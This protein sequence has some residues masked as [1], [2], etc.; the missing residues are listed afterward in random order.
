MQTAI[1]QLHDFLIESAARLP[2]K[3]ALVCEGQR[4]TYAEIDR[5]SSA[6]A[7]ALTSRGVE[8]GDRVIV[9]ADNTV[10]AVVSFFGVL[11]ANAVVSMVNPQ[12]KDDKLAYLLN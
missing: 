5:R 12:T 2:D 10:A 8:R 9:Y 4:F 3:E 11:K 1:P 7:H 6:L